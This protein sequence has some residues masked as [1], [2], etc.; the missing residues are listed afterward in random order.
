MIKISEQDGSVLVSVYALLWSA[1]GHRLRTPE[2]LF[3]DT[4][5]CTPQPRLQGKLPRPGKDF[6]SFLSQMHLNLWTRWHIRKV[7]RVSFGNVIRA[8][9]SLVGLASILRSWILFTLNQVVLDRLLSYFFRWIF[10]CFFFSILCL[11]QVVCIV[12]ILR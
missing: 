5:L 10:C 1:P 12:C 4:L 8:W 6:L 2:L 9:R 11:D 3:Q 7:G